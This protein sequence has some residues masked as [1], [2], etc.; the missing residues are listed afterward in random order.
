V[1]AVA[2][3]FPTEQ[4]TSVRRSARL[5]EAGADKRVYAEPK[6]AYRQKGSGSGGTNMTRKETRVQ[7]ERKEEERGRGVSVG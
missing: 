3:V 6:R 4:H 7:V 1:G 2:V 5:A